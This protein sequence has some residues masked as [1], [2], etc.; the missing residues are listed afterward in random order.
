MSRGATSDKQPLPWHGRGHMTRPHPP[1][2]HGPTGGG[3][4]CPPDLTG[5]RVAWPVYTRWPWPLALKR[6]RTGFGEW[7]S[8]QV[9]LTRVAKDTRGRLRTLSEWKR[10]LHPAPI[11]PAVAR[12]VPLIVSSMQQ[13][14][15]H[16]NRSCLFARPRAPMACEAPSQTFY[17]SMPRRTKPDYTSTAHGL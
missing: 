5:W 8:D 6:R 7:L 3:R 17:H 11:R 2:Y 13:T 10:A 14:A 1:T 9:I 12:V 4:K 16:A 15:A